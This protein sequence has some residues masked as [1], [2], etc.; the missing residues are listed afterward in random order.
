MEYFC[1]MSCFHL[2]IDSITTEELVVHIWLVQ[3]I[4]IY[5]FFFFLHTTDHK[6]LF[7]AIVSEE[8]VDAPR[9]DR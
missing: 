3:R 6:Q 1:L 8:L 5:L 4:E 9:T 7:R 2:F